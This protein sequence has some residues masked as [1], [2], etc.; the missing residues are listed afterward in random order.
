MIRDP[1]LT[2]KEALK[3]LDEIDLS[4]DFSLVD[5][6]RLVMSLTREERELYYDD[7]R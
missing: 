1:I 3:L 2:P 4:L 7:Q 5:E 6:F